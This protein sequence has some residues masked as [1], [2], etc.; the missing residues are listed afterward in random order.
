MSP[1]RDAGYGSK[2]ASVTSEKPNTSRSKKS[3]SVI[4][5]VKKAQCFS[6][7]VIWVS[8]MRHHS[9]FT[10]IVALEAYEQVCRSNLPTRLV[11]YTY[12]RYASKGL[13]RQNQMDVF[14]TDNCG[15]W[16][17][18][19]CSDALPKSAGKRQAVQSLISF[20]EH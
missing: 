2:I 6:P 1:L 3:V 19:R 12:T 4:S 7:E 13:I 16:K 8:R 11:E 9:L 5:V 10:R 18:Q 20:Q 14:F 17:H 15:V